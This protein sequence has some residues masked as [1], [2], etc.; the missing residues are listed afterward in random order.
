MA[1]RIF[2]VI[3][4][5]ASAIALSACVTTS[6]QGYADLQP[7]ASPIQHIAAIAPP[8]LV[9]ALARE[10]SKR[11]V[12]VEDANVILP[13]TRQYNET[14]V[15]QAMAAH[16]IDGVL[17]VNVTGDTGV[18]QQYAGTI[19]DTSYS[20]TSSGNATVMGNMIYGTGMSSGTATTTTTPI[21]RYKRA[22]AFEARLSDPQTSRK[23]W[24]GGGQTQAGGALFMGDAASASNAASAI[25]ND[26]QTKGLIGVRSS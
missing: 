4:I 19:A 14:E 6:M 12:V 22:T 8:A 2:A 10:A 5:A 13:P 25:F 18:Q 11:G 3:V 26:L 7:P 1:S 21:F 9:P 23:F 17:V 24:V 16:G 15:R 20:G